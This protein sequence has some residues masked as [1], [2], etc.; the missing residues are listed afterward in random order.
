[1]I[2][3]QLS[4][5]LK[6]TTAKKPELKRHD[7]IMLSSSHSSDG[8]TCSKCGR[9]Y[10][11]KGSLNKHEK[12]ECVGAT[13]FKCFYCPRTAKHKY[14]LL[15]HVVRL[16]PERDG[17]T[18]SKCG[19]VYNLK[20]SLNRHKKYECVGATPFKCFYCP[21]TAKHKYNLLNHV[22][23]LHPERAE[24]FKQWYDT[25]RSKAIVLH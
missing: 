8:K 25:N 3:G 15:N 14:N 11:L 4:I 10:N 13:P 5:N 6:G 16:H 19:R 17:K 12:Y 2:V 21:R 7:N 18:C 24:E 1:M 23:R 20:G 22:V 9:V